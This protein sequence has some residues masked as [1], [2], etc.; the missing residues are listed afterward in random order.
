MNAAD[1]YNNKPVKIKMKGVVVA[2]FVNRI[3]YVMPVQQVSAVAGVQKQ[4]GE[5]SRE[6]EFE[7]IFE[8]SKAK[9]KETMTEAAATKKTGYGNISCCYGK[10][11]MELGFAEQPIFDAIR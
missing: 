8:A 7:R 11:A 9:E 1:I 5:Q 2:V 6:R 4:G 3:N 10:H